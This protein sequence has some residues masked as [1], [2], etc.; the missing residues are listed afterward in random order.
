M[1]LRKVFL[2]FVDYRK[3]SL[4]WNVS[5]IMPKHRKRVSRRYVNPKH[6]DGFNEPDD[7]KQTRL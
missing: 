5:L 7:D 4:H 1:L 6:N 2:A 3:Y